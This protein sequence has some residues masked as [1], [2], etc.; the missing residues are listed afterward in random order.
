MVSGAVALDLRPAAAPTLTTTSILVEGKPIARRSLRRKKSGATS[1]RQDCD[2]PEPARTQRAEARKE[3]WPRRDNDGG[4]SIAIV[5]SEEK[6]FRVL[7]R[8]FT[9]ADS[10]R[11]LV[12]RIERDGGALMNALRR[13]RRSFPDS[14]LGWWRSWRSVRGAHSRLHQ[15]SRPVP[16]P[17]RAMAGAVLRPNSR[18]QFGLSSSQYA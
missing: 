15:P 8:A 1:S 10:A 4:E 5:P 13:H 6:T 2:N 7:F 16:R 14:Q 12:D 3:V 17:K 11:E 18:Y 9:H